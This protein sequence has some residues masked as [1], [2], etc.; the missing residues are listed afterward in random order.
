MDAQDKRDDVLISGI[1][2]NNHLPLRGI[3][4]RIRGELDD[5]YGTVGDDA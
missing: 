5:Y 1:G 4:N 2:A 3:E